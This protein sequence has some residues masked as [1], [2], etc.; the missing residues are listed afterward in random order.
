MECHARWNVFLCMRIVWI[1]FLHELIEPR[2]RCLL[3]W[4]RTR[5]SNAATAWDFVITVTWPCSLFVRRLKNNTRHSGCK[6][7][8]WWDCAGVTGPGR[9]G[10]TA[11]SV[12]DNTDTGVTLTISGTSNGVQNVPNV[13][14]LIWW[15]LAFEWFVLES[16]DEYQVGWRY[17]SHCW[18]VRRF[19]ATEDSHTH[20]VPLVSVP[21]PALV[22]R[23]WTFQMS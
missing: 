8:Q 7:R 10:V 19:E 18:N 23:L 3:T 11:Y 6:A 1:V 21:F 15:S 16:C 17:W 14:L 5:I 20:W 13:N 22:W 12:D 4:R 2:A 9:C